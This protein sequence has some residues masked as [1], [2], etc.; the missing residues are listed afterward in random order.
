MALNQSGRRRFLGVLGGTAL[1]GALP[2]MAQT[3]KNVTETPDGFTPDLE[4]ELRAAPDQIAILPGQSTGVW[5][6]RAKVLKGPA[7]A[8]TTIPGSYLGPIINVRR[9]TRVRV[10]FINELPQPSV[11]HWHGLIIPEAMDGHPR[12]VVPPGGR[13]TYEFEVRNRAGTYW[14]HPHPDQ[15]TGTQVNAGLAGLFIVTDDEE[16]ALK[17]P[18]GE[19]DVALVIQDRSFTSDNQLRYVGNGPGMAG[20]MSRM[21]GFIGDQ[22]LVNGRPD[23]SLAVERRPY[24]LRLLNGSNS[25]IY[26]LAWNDSSPMT[27][28]GSDGGLLYAPVRRTYITLA[29]AERIEL[30][31]DFSTRVAGE[32]LTLQSQPFAASTGGSMMG[33][34]MGGSG[35]LPNGAEFPVLKVRIGKGAAISEK[36]PGM[37]TSIAPL[38]PEQASNFANPR[39]FRTTMVGMRWGL[40]GRVFEMDGVA[41][42][43]VVRLGSTEIWEFINEA[44]MGMMGGGMPHPIHIHGVQF[45]IIGR[46]VQPAAISAWHS[47]NEGYVD[48][49]WK[50]TVLLMPG[51]RVRLLMRFD[52]YPGMFVYHCH[53]LEHEDMGMMRNFL[54]KA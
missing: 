46:R 14:F 32:E 41:K 52:N 36:L 53:N 7:N 31:V 30:W 12:Y 1:L 39:T 40:N 27:V 21:N 13:Y 8:V 20:M 34:M 26:K 29:P 35:S 19:R 5:R 38:R 22:I 48:E 11:V 42:D 24:R 44:S 17:L 3:R 2:G 23:F 4:L 9:G 25:R 51:E 47:L 6:Y 16:R 33:G 45:R 15:L 18:D 49:G 43:E 10:N 28:I 54:I 37:L 50:D